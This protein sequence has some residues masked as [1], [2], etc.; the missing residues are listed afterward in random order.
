[1]AEDKRNCGKDA[2]GALTAVRTE[3]PDDVFDCGID[4][5]VSSCANCLLPQ[6]PVS[7]LQGNYRSRTSSVR[8][9]LI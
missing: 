4:A 8:R 7:E 5:S 6:P 3:T 2:R 9:D 1:M